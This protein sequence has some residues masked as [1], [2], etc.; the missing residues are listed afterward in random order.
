MIANSF[1]IV[2]LYFYYLGLTYAFLF[3][4]FSIDRLSAADR[5]V[6]VSFQQIVDHTN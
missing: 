3:Q 6:L 1:E 2:G 4:F 5:G